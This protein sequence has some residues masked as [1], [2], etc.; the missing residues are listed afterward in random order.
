VADGFEQVEL[1]EPRKALEEAG[2]RTQIVSTSK[3]RVQGWKHFD[4]SDHFKVDVPIHTADA[5]EFDALLLPGGVAN[6]EQLRTNPEAVA[7]V[8]EFV[9]SGKPIAV[10]DGFPTDRVEQ[11]SRE[12]LGAAK[13]VPVADR[14]AKLTQYFQQLFPD[15]GRDPGRLLA[16]GVSQPESPTDVIDECLGRPR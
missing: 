8:R 12:D 1:T 15:S 3:D 4:E 9:E 2:A 14:D 10:N 11:I 6:P 13:L 5:E 16:L 7:F